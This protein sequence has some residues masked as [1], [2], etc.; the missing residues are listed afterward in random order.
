M[1]VVLVLE[2]DFFSQMALQTDI[3][4]ALVGLLVNCEHLE[5]ESLTPMVALLQN[6]C[7]SML[8]YRWGV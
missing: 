8:S 4:L 6:C 2:R 3:P 5:I 7:I 1:S